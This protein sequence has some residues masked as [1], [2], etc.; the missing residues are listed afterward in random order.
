MSKKA[1]GKKPSVHVVPD[2]RSGKWPVKH[3]GSKRPIKV[4]DTQREAERFGRELAR[5]EKTEFVLHGR[6]GKIREK[7]SYGNDPFPPRDKEH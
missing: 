6:D 4:F 3:A 5:K 7:D 1:G 2:K